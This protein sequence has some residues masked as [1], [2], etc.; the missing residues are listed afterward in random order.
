MNKMLKMVFVFDNTKFRS[1]YEKI[2][3]KEYLLE[4]I[5]ID[6]QV[7][8]LRKSNEEENVVNQNSVE[9]KSKK[10]IKKVKRYKNIS[11]RKIFFMSSYIYLALAIVVFSLSIQVLSY[12]WISNLNTTAKN[13]LDVYILGIEQWN[14]FTS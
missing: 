4:K 3:S 10:N 7:K 1:E 6:T 2:K 12:L 5:L 11:S 14:S 9:I 13:L 8:S